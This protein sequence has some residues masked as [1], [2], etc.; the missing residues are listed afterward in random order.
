MAC[1]YR[2]T[3]ACSGDVPSPAFVVAAIYDRRRTP[4][5]SC[6]RAG[7]DRRYSPHRPDEP[8]T[9]PQGEG[10][11]EGL[12]RAARAAPPCIPSPQLIRR[13]D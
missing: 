5:P 1:P 4:V 2:K 8:S 7:A 6:V 11:G 3:H 12:G 13:L 9:L 10:R